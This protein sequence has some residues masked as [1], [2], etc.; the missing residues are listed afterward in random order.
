MSLSFRL[1]PISSP[2]PPSHLRF[3]LLSRSHLNPTSIHYPSPSKFVSSSPIRCVNQGP[4]PVSVTRARPRWEN[5]LSA[6][7]SLY[8]VYV[9]VGGVVACLKPS[10]FQW[11]VERGPTSYSLSLGLIMLSMGLTL[12]LKDMISLFLQRPL[13]VILISLEILF[14][15]VSRSPRSRVSETGNLVNVDDLLLGT[16][17]TVD[18]F[19]LI[20]RSKSLGEVAFCRSWEI[21]RI[22]SCSRL[23]TVWCLGVLDLMALSRVSGV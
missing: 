14:L 3:T 4:D 20:S 13:S 9:S 22:W 17:F 21:Y 23:H 12:E 2:P 10:A 6:A 15:L 5:A 18:S 11:F 7:A 19:N 8:P 16:P 1:T